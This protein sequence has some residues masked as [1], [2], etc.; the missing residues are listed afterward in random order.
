MYLLN[1]KVFLHD[2]YSFWENEYHCFYWEG[3]VFIRSIREGVDSLKRF[4]DILKTGKLEDSCSKLS[5]VFFLVVYD[6]TT[7]NYYCFID[8]CGLFRAFYSDAHIST[9]LLKLRKIENLRKK[10]LNVESITEFLHLGHIHFNKTYFDSI[11]KFRD[12]QIIRIS[13]KGEMQ[14]LSKKVIDVFEYDPDRLDKRYDDFMQIFQEICDS[15]RQLRIS[16][17]LTGGFDS[18]LIAVLF[19]YF[20]LDFETGITGI[21]KNMD[22]VI[23][24]KVAKSLSCLHRIVYHSPDFSDD[25][26]ETLF[27][28]CDGRINILDY[29]R[30]LPYQQN[31]LKSGIELG[32]TG[33]GAGFFKDYWWWQD[34]PFYNSRRINLERFIDS[35][36]FRIEPRHLYLSNRLKDISYNLKNDL[37]RKLQPFILETNTRTYDKIAYEYRGKESIGEDMSI[38]T[39]FIKSYTPFM[40]P[41]LLRIGLNFPRI[42]RFYNIFHRRIITKVNPTVAGIPTTDSGTSASSRLYMLPG[43]VIKYAYNKGLSL[44]RYTGRKVLKTNFLCPGADNPDLFR[45]IRDSSIAQQSVEYL[46]D[47][48]IISKEIS[49]SDIDNSYMGRIITLAKLLQKLS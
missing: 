10:D 48:D 8:N 39:R 23:S 19:N 3:L 14:S 49:V 37:I 12:D 9:S 33:D 46:Q 40:E 17:S 45:K 29:H 18:R 28:I 20:N 43:D 26:L 6:K 22:I 41:E 44:T 38:Q 2:N 36:I 21:E 30:L 15:F 31:R 35:R 16:L 32:I 5:G 7:S 47:E 1:Q 42:E 24:S 13:L 11:K 34:L 4:S 27:D 25:L